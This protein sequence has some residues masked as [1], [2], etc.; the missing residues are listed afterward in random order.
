MRLAAAL[1]ALVLCFSA[2]EGGCGEAPADSGSSS[3]SGQTVSGNSGGGGGG[4]SAIPLTGGRRQAGKKEGDDNPLA[5]PKPETAPIRAAG[6]VEKSRPSA[7]GA[8]DAPAGSGPGAVTALAAV[9][10]VTP[11]DFEAA[12]LKSK[13]PVLVLYLTSSCRP[14]AHVEFALGVMAKDYAGKV[15]FA[16]MDLNREGATLLLPPGLRRLPLPAMAFYQ[17]GSPLNIRQG[18]PVPTDSSS[19]LRGWLKRVADGRD[20]RLN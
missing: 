7:S 1:L 20:V 9:R 4:D 13:E 10:D 3:G 14:C 6:D 16:R 8:P 17:G 2:C 15:A 12:V 11:A 19:Q 18:I 5:A